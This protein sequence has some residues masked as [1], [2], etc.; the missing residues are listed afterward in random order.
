[1]Q[2]NNFTIVDRHNRPTTMDAVGLR[3]IF[4]NDGVQVDPYAISAVSIFVKGKVAAALDSSGMLSGEPLMQFSN[5]VNGTLVSSPAD[6]VF[7]ATNYNPASGG[8]NCSLLT[9]AVTCAAVSGIYRYSTA[10]PGEFV[11]VLN[12]GIDL[13]GIWDGVAGSSLQNAASSVND[14]VDVWTVKLSQNSNWQILVNEFSLFGDT[15]FSITQPMML[16]TR[17]SLAN[18]HIQLG[19]KVNVKIPT[20]IT[21]ENKDIDSSIKNLFKQSIVTSASCEI[22][23]LND[24]VTLPSRVTVYSFADTTGLVDITSDNTLVYSWDTS[25]L[26]TAL[27]LAGGGTA[28]GTYTIQAKYTLID[29]VILSP[30][31]PLIVS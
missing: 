10:S 27:A 11:V 12:G 1:M 15:F 22:V 17:N 18:K 13:S 4:V 19:S 9:G 23:K 5:V 16:K 2:L 6:A 24:D 8:A 20:E 29:E 30:R 28:T 3:T 26:A 7:D 14:Y 21:V 25:T 31:F